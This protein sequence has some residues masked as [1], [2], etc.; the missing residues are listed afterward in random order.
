M[1]DTD[2]V[3]RSFNNFK[4]FNTGESF[5]DATNGSGANSSN[6]SGNREH[7]EQGSHTAKTESGWGFFKQ[8]FQPVVNLRYIN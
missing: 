1:E 8:Y 7:V 4:K 2:K 6:T 3:P 5:P